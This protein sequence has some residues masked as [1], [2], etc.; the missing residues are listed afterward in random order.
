MLNKSL[1][2]FTEN[3][4]RGGG[5]RYMIDLIN[6]ISS[7]YET[8]SM[9][10]NAEGISQ[11]DVQRLQCKYKQKNVFFLSSHCISQV[12]Y[13]FPRLVELFRLILEPVI[14]ISNIVIFFITIKQ[15][16]PDKIVSCN[17]GYPA[18]WSCLAMVVAA[19]LSCIP[20]ILSIVSM[21]SLRKPYTRFYEKFIDKLV[22]KSVDMILVNAK[23]IARALTD[24]R[25][26]KVKRVEVVYNGIDDVEFCHSYKNIE[27]KII[28]GCIAR[29]DISKGVLLL[30]E[31]FA[32][33]TKIYSN[34]QMLLIGQGDA[35]VELERRMMELG[36]QNQI[37][38]MGYYEGDIV[39]VINNFDIYV[40][41]SLWEGLPYSIIEALRAAR[42]IIATK[43]GGIPEIIRN[44][45][46]GILIEPGSTIEIL[47]AIEKLINNEY[48]RRKLAKNARIKFEEEL[49]INHMNL[50][51]RNAILNK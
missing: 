34:I 48:L 7:D 20:V 14:F 41:P 10:S 4:A 12:K 8:I 42:V 25:D 40:F 37:H 17:G 28:I 3:Y 13:I 38:L 21:P 16:K 29:M 24:L 36:L 15:I 35:S 46:E 2:V 6:A 5:N 27:G 26:M 31:A 49:T 33:L 30:L 1:L 23:S 18:A 39:N 32:K 9:V 45:V 19:K 47:N 22:W 43:V 50:R 11:H 51:M 44:E